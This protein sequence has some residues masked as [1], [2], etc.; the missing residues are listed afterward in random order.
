M[1]RRSEIGDLGL[2]ESTPTNTEIII[3]KKHGHHS[4]QFM[5]WWFFNHE[6]LN[7]KRVLLHGKKTGAVIASCFLQR[8]FG[9]LWFNYL[10]VNLNRNNNEYMQFRWGRSINCNG[11]ISRAR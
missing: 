5:A 8:F 2:A 7:H 9:V 11:Y 3:N 6:E 1:A 4:L 10:M